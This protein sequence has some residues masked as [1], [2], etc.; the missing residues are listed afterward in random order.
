V[1]NAEVE[2]RSKN[3]SRRL[4]LKEFILGP[5]KTTL[6]PGEIV[7]GIWVK[8]APGYNLHHFEKVGQRKALAISIASLAGLLRVSENGGIEEARLAWGSV[9]PTII[10]SPKVEKA[11]VGNRLSRP[12]LGE[13]ARLARGA[14]EPIDDIRASAEYRRQVS[15]NLLLRL[16]VEDG[17]TT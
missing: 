8:K 12:V 10:T 14:V 7:S 6:Q 11:L 13:A 15:G 16:S 9:G 2:I 5:G 3:A 4:A 1:L 17:K